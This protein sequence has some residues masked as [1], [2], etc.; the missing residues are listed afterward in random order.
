MGAPLGPS[1]FSLALWCSYG[2]TKQAHAPHLYGSSLRAGQLVAYVKVVHLNQ[3]TQPWPNRA[4][5]A[6]TLVLLPLRKHACGWAATSL[7][8]DYGH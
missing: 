5:V 3:S 2:Q 7:C 1:V 6:R 4:R 8:K